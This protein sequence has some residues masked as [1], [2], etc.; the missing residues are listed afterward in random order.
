M[1]SVKGTRFVWGLAGERKAQHA[2]ARRRG[3]VMS[4]SIYYENLALQSV[5]RKDDRGEHLQICL[6]GRCEPTY[7]FLVGWHKQICARTL[8]E[9]VFLLLLSS[10]DHRRRRLHAPISAPHLWRRSRLQAPPS[11]PLSS[12]SSS[13]LLSAPHPPPLAHPPQPL[14]LLLLLLHPHPF[15]HSLTSPPNPLGDP[16]RGIPPSRTRT[17]LLSHLISFAL[18]S[19]M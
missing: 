8:R 2:C 9:R 15:P 7:F 13:S 6:D 11:L 5:R 18:S 10:L 1:I 17:L 14:L 12:S 4:D 16:E 19:A 3:N